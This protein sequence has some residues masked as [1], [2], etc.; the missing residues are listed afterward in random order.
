MWDRKE[1]KARGRAAFKANYWRCVLVGVLLMLFA[2][3]SATYSYR[4]SSDKLDDPQLSVSGQAGQITVNGKSYD[5][6]QDAITAIGEAE[7]AKPEDVAALNELIDRLQNDPE[8]QET[9]AIVLAAIGVGLLIIGLI[10]ALVRVFVFGPLE[11]GCQTFFLRNAEA[12]APVGEIGAG[13]QPYWR[14]VGAMFLRGLYLFLWSL[15]LVIPGIIKA[16]SYRM[17]PYILADD[18]TISGKEAITLSRRMMDGQKWNAFVLDLSFIG[19]HILSLLTLGLVGIFYVN[20]YH[21]CT[22]AEL[23]RELVRSGN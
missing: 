10:A 22:G 12:P 4:S 17:V 19:W 11:L 13:F 18:P 3:G 1:L 14:N 16:Y 21:F 9:F 20:P 15:L 6:L 5:S 2:A 8:T 7:N 23:Y